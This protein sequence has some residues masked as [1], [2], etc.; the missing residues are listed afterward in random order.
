MGEG[1]A[2]N[3]GAVRIGR[4]QTTRELGRGGMGVVYEAADPDIGRRV[5]IKLINLQAFMGPSEAQTLRERLFREARSAGALSHPGIVTVY[6]VGQDQDKAFIAMEFVDGP[7]LQQLQA[8]GNLPIAQVVDILRQTAAALDY[9]HQ[10]GVVHRDI[11]PA[12][13]ML[14]KG[15]QVKIADFGIAKLTTAPKYTMTGL[16]MGTPAYMSPEQIEGREVDGRSDQFSLAVVAYEL[17][18]GTVPFQ[19]QTYASMV[20]G[21]VYGPRPSAKAVNAALPA[22]FDDVLRRAMATSA[23]ERF[24]SCTGFAFALEAAY[25][26]DAVRAAATLP[27]P[28]QPT[29][30]QPPVRRAQPATK[31]MPQAVAPAASPPPGAP[32]PTLPTYQTAPAGPSKPRR[33]LPAMAALVLVSLGLAAAVAYKFGVFSSDETIP[34]PID[35]TTGT[36]TPPVNPPAPTGSTA[37]YAQPS[38]PLAS[39]GSTAAVRDDTASKAVMQAPEEARPRENVRRRPQVPAGPTVQTVSV[40]ADRAWTDTGIDLLRTDST[41]ITATGTI[42]IAADA[43]RVRNQ[44]PGGFLPNC[45]SPRKFFGH[46]KGTVPGPNL[47]CWSLLARVGPHGP[48][49]EIGMKGE[50]P[51]GAAGRLY[52]GVNDDDFSDNSGSWTA[53]VKVEHRVGR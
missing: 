44:Q 37:G 13:I 22:A 47:S 32:Q 42:Q 18:T 20:H 33:L 30:A 21:I 48:L 5:A 12:N 9:A 23:D 8:R 11:K 29:A 10:N 1:L 46:P 38:N 53:T 50:I 43:P 35:G 52:L 45:D 17:F 34:P 26:S 15:A 36:Y 24:E 25:E 14:H 3:D 51:A 49:M 41:S 16:V 28:P 31:T 6:D 39:T 27:L 4:Y 2:G 19:G 40:E 7:S